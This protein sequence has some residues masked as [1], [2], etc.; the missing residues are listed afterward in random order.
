MINANCFL[1]VGAELMHSPLVTMLPHNINNFALT[2][3]HETD[4]N[5]GEWQHTRAPCGSCLMT[6][7]ADIIHT[8]SSEGL[9]SVRMSERYT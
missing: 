9:M 8:Q 5:T 7:V 2:Q 4:T 6:A 3:Q 1:S